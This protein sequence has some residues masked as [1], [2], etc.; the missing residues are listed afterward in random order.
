MTDK[1]KKIISFAS[2]EILRFLV[3]VICSVC[4]AL[5]FIFAVIIFFIFRRDPILGG[6]LIKITEIILSAAQA[7]YIYF[8]ILR[9]SPF[10]K[11]L[12]EK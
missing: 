4:I 9:I 11:S 7:V 6:K 5:L 1:T 12:G 8:L 10:A 2:I 3:F